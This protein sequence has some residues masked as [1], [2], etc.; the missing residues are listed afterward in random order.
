MVEV[1]V[2]LR[3]YFEGKEEWFKERGE[4]LEESEYCINY[5]KKDDGETRVI[6]SKRGF[7]Y[8]NH[9]VLK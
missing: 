9:R 4:L 1:E 6:V 8:V 3:R 2:T 7:D 5:I